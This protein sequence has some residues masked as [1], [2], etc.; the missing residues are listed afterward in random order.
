[1]NQYRSHGDGSFVSDDF[2][3]LGD[4]CVIEPG[5]MVFHPENITLGENVYVGHRAMLKGYHRNEMV[6]GDNTWIGQDCFFHSAGGLTIGNTVGI[7]PGVRILTSTHRDPG[8]PNPIMEGELVFAP[9]RIGDGS[10]I[11]IGASLR[12]A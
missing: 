1:M 12:G 4:H 6:I 10:D 8:T 2:A 3:G 9:V 11:G 5:V 7:G